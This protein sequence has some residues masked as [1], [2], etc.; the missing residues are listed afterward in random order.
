VNGLTYALKYFLYDAGGVALTFVDPIHA[1][2]LRTV[3]DV[4]GTV[5]NGSS[6]SGTVATIDHH[7][8]MTL[9]GL[10]STTRTLNGTSRDRDVVTTSGVTNMR[11][12]ID[13]TGTT[14]NLVLPSGSSKW[15][16]S[17]TITSI[18]NSATTI[19]SL[20]Q[21]TTS[22][23]AVLTF[24]GTSTATLVATV[25]GRVTTCQIDLTGA[26]SPRCA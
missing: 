8:D 2:S 25:S 23:N 26:T 6:S 13:L 21:V 22:A 4:T 10:L 15:P 9:G 16:A 5:T 18:A 11:T 17:G 3:V 24:N 20:P 1:A 7:S 12:S 14:A 19:G